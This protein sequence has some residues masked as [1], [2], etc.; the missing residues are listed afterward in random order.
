MQSPVSAIPEKRAELSASQC[1]SGKQVLELDIEILFFE[2]PRASDGWP[3]LSQGSTERP[4]KE[5]CTGL[6]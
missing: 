4:L 2:L 5:N 1:V 3:F 6:M